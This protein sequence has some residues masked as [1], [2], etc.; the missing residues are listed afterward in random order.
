MPLTEAATELAES[1]KSEAIKM[2]Q[3]GR[4]ADKLLMV[5]YKFY[6]QYYVQHSDECSS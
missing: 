1:D 5:Y 4:S 2:H 6:S 3:A